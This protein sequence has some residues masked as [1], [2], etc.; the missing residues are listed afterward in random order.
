MERPIILVLLYINDNNRENT[1]F[2]IHVL[3]ANNEFI[4][5]P[6]VL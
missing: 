4:F 2:K 3:N 5:K 1:K 6:P